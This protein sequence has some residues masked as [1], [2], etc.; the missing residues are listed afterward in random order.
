MNEVSATHRL[1]TLT[2]SVFI[3]V[4]W[5]KK[6]R[7]PS[8]LCVVKCGREHGNDLGGSLRDRVTGD[9]LSVFYFSGV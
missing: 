8:D 3:H 5:E 2:H 7:T 1:R 9:I 4:K 6:P